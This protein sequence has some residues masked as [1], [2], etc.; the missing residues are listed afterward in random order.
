V[1]SLNDFAI[2]G[3]LYR[4]SVLFWGDAAVG[5]C[6]KTCYTDVEHSIALIYYFAYKIS[7]KNVDSVYLVFY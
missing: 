5:L 7:R 4:A 6:D 2:A 3:S 1:C